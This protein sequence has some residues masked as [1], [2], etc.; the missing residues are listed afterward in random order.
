MT[1]VPLKQSVL[2]ETFTELH[3]A[4]LRANVTAVSSMIIKVDFVSGRV[5]AL[6][7]GDVFSTHPLRH[8]AWMFDLQMKSD[9]LA[10]QLR[11]TISESDIWRPFARERSDDI[12]AF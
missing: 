6:V 11:N 9:D 8:D 3:A 7:A 4:C 12:T 5:S 10:E 1:D 2:N